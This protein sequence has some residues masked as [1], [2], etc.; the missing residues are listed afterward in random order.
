MNKNVKVF[1]AGTSRNDEHVVTAGGRVLCVTSLG[2]TVAEAQQLVAEL[3]PGL[4]AVKGV[5]RVL[6]PPFTALVMYI[7]VYIHT[8][9]CFGQ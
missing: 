5:D 7:P 3:I 9:C 8:H 1:H 6:C 4:D 2:E